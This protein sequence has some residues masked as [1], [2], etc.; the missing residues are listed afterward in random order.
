MSNSGKA[1]SALAGWGSAVLR[2]ALS[3]LPE[4]GLERQAIDA[5]EIDAVVDYANANVILFPLERHALHEAAKLASTAPWQAPGDS[6]LANSVLAALPRADYE[7]LVF[8]LDPVTLELGNV[9]HEPGVPV[10]YVY[11]PIDCAVCLLTRTE[12]QRAVATGMVG[13]EGIVG[14]SLVFGVDVSSVRAQVIAGGKALRM[15]AWRFDQ[16]LRRCPSLQRELYRYAYGELAQARQTAACIDSHRLEQRLA[17]WILMTSDRSR[18]PDIALTQEHLA[19]DLNVRRVSITLACTALRARKLISYKRG[20][21]RIVS[22][23]GLEGASCA[24][25]TRIEAVHEA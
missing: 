12:G 14:V 18:S 10:R 19:A 9:L 6:P 23:K 13:Y 8:G 7:R 17:C 24:C 22:R 2:R 21:M 1:E 5:G 11:F 25:Y 3:Q 16:E 20:K 15:P 4:G